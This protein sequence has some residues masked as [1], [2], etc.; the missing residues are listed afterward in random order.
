M[1]ELSVHEAIFTA[2]AVRH[3]KTD[4]IPRADLEY[5]IEAAT[6][7]P[8]AGNMQMWSFV[9]VTD[10]D[11]M[12]RMADT[13]RDVGRQY[14][15]DGV[16]ADPQLDDA[17]RKIYTGAMHNVEHLD[18]AGAIIV[19]C[20]TMPCPDNVGVASGLFGSI[21]P[22]IQNITLAARSR[23]LG[24][25]MITLATDHCPVG[26]KAHPPIR[27]ILVLPEGVEAVALIPVGYPERR[28]GRPNR[29]PAA[30]CTHWDRWSA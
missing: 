30:K 10:R 24:T 7:A 14:I 13:H 9:V 5:L 2:R 11:Q 15:R 12:R 19:A 28:F 21:Y 22:A 18:E 8:S 16:L 1:P 6:M 4:P 3:L 20:L 17:R 29:R 27:E 26:P 23:E 25:V